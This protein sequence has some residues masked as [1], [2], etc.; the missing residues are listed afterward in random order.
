MISTYLELDYQGVNLLLISKNIISISLNLFK[1][2]Y[3]FWD[4]IKSEH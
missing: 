3:A 1:A 2:Y 4:I